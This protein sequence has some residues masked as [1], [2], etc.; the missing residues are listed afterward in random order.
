M[1]LRWL[2]VATALTFMLF[3]AGVTQTRQLPR[4]KVSPEVEVVLPLFVQV[5]MAAGDRYLAANAATIRA[6]VTD[7]GRMRPEEY[8]LLAQWQVGASWLNPAHEDNYYIAS[9]VLPWNGQVGS[10]QKILY[11]ASLSRPQD[12]QPSFLYAFHLLHFYADP[13]GAAEWLRRSAERLTNPDEQL[14]MQNL[15]AKW[16]DR[17][18]D[19]DHAIGMVAA[20]ANQAKRKDFQRY[21]EMRVERLRGLKALR[22]AADRFVTSRKRPLRSLN[23]LV[24]AGYIDKVPVDPLGLGYALAADGQIVISTVSQK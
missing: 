6:L 11:R 12:Y 23:E 5:G 4:H 1:A 24:V 7:T 14:V 10:A 15:A 22:A 16:M 21:L 18:R 8:P 2:P 19:L 3:V 9:A 20:L 13:A 17:S